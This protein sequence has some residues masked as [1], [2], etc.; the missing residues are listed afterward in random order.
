MK[1]QPQSPKRLRWWERPADDSTLFRIFRL[2]LRKDELTLIAGLLILI[3]S[4][5]WLLLTAVSVVVA[6]VLCAVLIR[7]ANRKDSLS[8][9]RIDDF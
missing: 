5:P 4:K 2:L 7:F 6:G 9:L 1:Q 8:V 3:V